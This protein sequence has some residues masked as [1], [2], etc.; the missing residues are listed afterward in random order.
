MEERGTLEPFT[1]PNDFGARLPL[2]KSFER[3]SALVKKVSYNDIEDETVIEHLLEAAGML[4]SIYEAQ[5]EGRLLTPADQAELDLLRITRP[6]SSVVKSQ[7]FGLSAEERRAVEL[8]AMKLAEEWLHHQGY[9]TKDTSS[10]KPYDFEAKKDGVSLY[11]EVKGTTSDSAE[12]IL[13]THGEVDLHSRHKGQTALMIVTDIRLQKG[14]EKVGASGGIL[15]PLV[16][17]DIDDW[18]LKPT[19]YRV[20]R[21][22]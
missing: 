3:A 15:E 18:T 17:W 22:T 1:D 8:R 12:A 20:V 6:T 5:R 21:S 13:M 16:G 10:N 9:T 19:A 7:G 11:V 4:K 2:P 14:E